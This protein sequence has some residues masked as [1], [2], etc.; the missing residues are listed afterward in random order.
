MNNQDFLRLV[1][2]VALYFVGLTYG[3]C[4]VDPGEYLRELA[5]VQVGHVPWELTP[6]EHAEI[7]KLATELGQS[8]SHN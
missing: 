8:I 5:A 3:I 1:F 2:G 7:N 6:D 4:L